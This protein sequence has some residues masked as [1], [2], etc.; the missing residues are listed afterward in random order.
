MHPSTESTNRAT[1]EAYERAA[2]SYVA[3]TSTTPPPHLSSLLDR[4]GELLPP[5]A[6]LLEIGSA[7]GRDADLL[8]GRGYAVQRTD[9]ASSFV[10]LSRQRGLRVDRL[11]VL[12]EEVRGT[13]DVIYANAVFLHFSRSELVGV[14]A[15]LIPHLT[16]RG[17]LVFTVRE[18]DGEGWS[19]HKLDEP[20]HFTYWHADALRDV[21]ASTGWRVVDLDAWDGLPTGWLSVIA[22][23]AV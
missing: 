13:W 2:D 3:G 14:L 22:R 15:R 7:T 17:L 4:M 11:N 16:A 1:L 21:L 19:G 8:E 18:G 5:P 9:A 12:T 6:S 23:P 20:R 10:S